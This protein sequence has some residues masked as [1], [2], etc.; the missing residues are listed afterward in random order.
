MSKSKFLLF[1]FVIIIQ[2]FDL[3]LFQ[4]RKYNFLF[5]VTFKC[6]FH[7]K[8]LA[9]LEASKLSINFTVKLNFKELTFRNSDNAYLKDK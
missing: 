1:S 8:R 4:F 7:F 2:Y 5:I 6:V 3:K 9:V